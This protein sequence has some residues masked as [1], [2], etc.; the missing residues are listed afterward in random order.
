MNMKV[1][2]IDHCREERVPSSE[3]RVWCVE[4]RD[5]AVVEDHEPAAPGQ[6]VQAVRDA[7]HSASREERRKHRL[8]LLICSRKN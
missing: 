7:Q 3:Q 5:A 6:R 2:I 4:L 8:D 1:L